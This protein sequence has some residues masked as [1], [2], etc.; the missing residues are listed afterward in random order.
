MDTPLHTFTHQ[1]GTGLGAPMSTR[2]KRQPCGLKES[3]LTPRSCLAHVMQPDGAPMRPLLPRYRLV[4]V[5]VEAKGVGCLRHHHVQLVYRELAIAI[6]VES[7]EGRFGRQL[8]RLR[9]PVKLLR[10]AW[11]KNIACN[12]RLLPLAHK[13]RFRVLQH[14]VRPVAQPRLGEVAQDGLELLRYSA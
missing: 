1:P 13:V 7:L 11:L 4:L 6:D 2:A 14:I 3:T 12:P 9:H 8:E 5:R 10:R